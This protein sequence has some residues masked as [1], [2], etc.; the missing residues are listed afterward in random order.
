MSCLSI[1][2]RILA[3]QNVLG[4]AFLPKFWLKNIQVVSWYLKVDK[5]KTILENGIDKWY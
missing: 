2:E 1:V 5:K 3:K 4:N